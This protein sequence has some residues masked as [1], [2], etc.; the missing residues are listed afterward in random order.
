LK[1]YRYFCQTN[2]QYHYTMKIQDCNLREYEGQLQS[3]PLYRTGIERLTKVASCPDGN[4]VGDVQ[5][6]FD[7]FCEFVVFNECVRRPFFE[8]LSNSLNNKVG[9][10]FTVLLTNNKVSDSS[11]TYKEAYDFF[12]LLGK[13]RV[14]DIL[15]AYKC[16]SFTYN[17]VIDAI[18]KK[19][20]ELFL[21]AL[22][23]ADF[24]D[25]MATLW[26]LRYILLGIKSSGRNSSKGRLGNHNQWITGADFSAYFRAFTSVYPDKFIEN[27][28]KYYISRDL[29]EKPRRQ[30]ITRGLN[31]E[32]LQQLYSTT[33]TAD[34]R[35]YLEWIDKFTKM[36]FNQSDFATYLDS[37]T[38]RD[39]EIIAD[40]EVIAHLI[41]KM[42]V[43]G[44]KAEL[45]QHFNLDPI[46]CNEVD[47][48]WDEYYCD[49]HNINTLGDYIIIYTAKMLS[50]YSDVKEVLNDEEKCVLEWI[51][52]CSRYT[53][54]LRHSSSISVCIDN[55]TTKEP[56]DAFT[57]KGTNT[58]ENGEQL[59]VPVL[60]SKVKGTTPEEK[61]K[62]LILC[63]NRLYEELTK[64][65]GNLM[66]SERDLFVYRFSGIGKAFPLDSK[67][68]WRGSNVLLG[69]IVRNLLS[70]KKYAPEG[71]GIVATFFLSKTGKPINLGTAR[72]ITVTNFEL[73]KNNIDQ[74]FVEAVEILRR[75][76]FINAEYTSKRR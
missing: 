61:D 66:E 59:F 16:S 8:I 40:S 58:T 10:L 60:G 4:I 41:I 51:L 52:G 62:E 2:R 72:H 54:L 70:D 36:S 15:D 6:V 67:I 22:G 68:K 48:D 74:N 17:G 42:A 53:F 31:D 63:L 27:Y 7:A 30:R 25:M 73:E 23:N 34:G 57:Q 64:E 49:Y 43:N 21:S 50:I 75:C 18:A 14:R 37:I 32:E 11:L 9:S 5:P 44:H 76:G 69:H 38:N 71:L 47:D 39:S 65:G 46:K 35:Y 45:I 55:V 33:T 24:H 26:Q 28:V 19:D 3:I 56:I 1:F 29:A 13:R 20:Y 12:L